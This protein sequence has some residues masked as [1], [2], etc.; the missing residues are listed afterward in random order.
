[1]LEA[2]FRAIH[3]GLLLK[4]TGSAQGVGPHVQDDEHC[5]ER[6][7]TVGPQ[8][9]L[10][11]L[12]PLFQQGKVDCSCKPRGEHGRVPATKPGGEQAEERS[13]LGPGNKIQ[14]A[15]HAPPLL[16]PELRT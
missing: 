10:R 9:V 13:E 12:D 6:L 5:E 16:G 15:A 7:G 11:E 1:M 14:M 3:L 4:T 8:A 2:I